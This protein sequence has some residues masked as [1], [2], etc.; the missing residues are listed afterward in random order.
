MELPL[1]AVVGDDTNVQY[2]AKQRPL[3]RMGSEL[4]AQSWNDICQALA[5]E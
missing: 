5:T 1:G 3:F 4:K 2:S